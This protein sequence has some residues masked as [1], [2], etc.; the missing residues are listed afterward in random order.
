V[1]IF[2][3]GLA[4]ELQEDKRDENGLYRLTAMTGSPRYMAP[5]TSFFRKYLLKYVILLNVTHTHLFR[6]RFISEVGNGKPYNASCDIYSFAILF[7]EMYGCKVPFE[8]YTMKSLK[9][10]VWND[11]HKRPFIQQAWSDSIRTLLEQA[12]S[13]DISKRPTMAEI[14]KIL[15]N[16]CVSCRGGDD[17]GLSMAGGGR[18]LSS[19][20]L[21]LQ[22]K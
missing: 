8:L 2:D 17:S 12:W 9:A 14:T 16:E 6:F 3:F 22:E 5:G 20:D 4:K 1:K 13:H 21:S 10:K 18:P 15:R 11:P 19:V 7:W